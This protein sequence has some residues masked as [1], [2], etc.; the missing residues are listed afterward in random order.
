M[1]NTLLMLSLFTAANGCA[2]A[3]SQP[4]LGPD[5][6]VTDGDKYHVLLENEQV[7]VL[8]YHDEPGDKTHLHHHPHF[9]I[10]ALAPFRRQ[11][12]LGDGK[13]MVREFLEG[14]V[15]WMPEQSHVGENIG[16]VPTEALLIEVKAP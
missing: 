5:P 10:Y 9:V 15:A 11:L 2:H 12:T 6:A 14:D 4:E 16:D 7:R 13:T 8:R 3:A 1:R